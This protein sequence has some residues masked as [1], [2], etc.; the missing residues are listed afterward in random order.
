MRDDLNAD[1]HS[2]GAFDCFS[3]EGG[4][5]VVV[6]VFELC[7]EIFFLNLSDR[8]R[9]SW[10]VQAV[11]DHDVLKPETHVIGVGSFERAV[12]E[13]WCYHG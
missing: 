2:F 13:S 6:F 8:D 5:G 4:P 11:P 10:I 1:W 7:L 9:S 3:H 12:R